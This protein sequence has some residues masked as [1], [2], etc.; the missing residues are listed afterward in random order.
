MQNNVTKVPSLRGYNVLW[1][2]PGL[3]SAYP[4]DGIPPPS[5]RCERHLSHAEQD[6]DG[7]VT[8]PFGGD[9][10]QSTFPYT[11]E[12]KNYTV[13]LYQPRAAILDVKY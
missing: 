4:A 8:I 3:P 2:D 9:P 12:G 13:R 10:G 7:S 11:P 5:G 1:P 6:A